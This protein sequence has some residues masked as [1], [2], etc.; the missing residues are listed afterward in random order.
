MSEL[1]KHLLIP[2]DASFAPEID[3][4]TNFFQTIKTLGTLSE[5][6]KYIVIT[7]TGKTRVIGQNPK[8]GETY[9]GPDLKVGRFSDLPSA[10]DSIG[11]EEIFDL[12]ARSTGPTTVSPF[13]NLYGVNSPD[14]L[15]EK[16]YSFSITCMQRKEITHFLHSSFGCNCDLKPNELAVFENPWNHQEIRTGALGCARFWISFGIGNYLVPMITDSLNILNTQL[17]DAAKYAFGIEF[18]QGCINSED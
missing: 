18:S 2:A 12:S 5:E 1:Y 16:P 3:K 17:V 15:W 7:Q 14:M 11:E 4:V 10:I 13:S 9:Y 6:T 8:T